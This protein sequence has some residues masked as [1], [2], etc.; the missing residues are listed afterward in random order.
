MSTKLVSRPASE[1]FAAERSPNDLAENQGAFET[2][3][4]IQNHFRLIEPQ[5]S[6]FPAA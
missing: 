6:N 5:P 1:L 4:D 2:I 3:W